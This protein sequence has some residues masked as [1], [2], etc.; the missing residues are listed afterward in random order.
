M[1]RSDATEIL[2]FFD[3]MDLA[4]KYLLGPIFKQFLGILTPKFVMPSIYPPKVC[5]FP[6]DMHYE[7][8]IIKI[9]SWVC[10]VGLFQKTLC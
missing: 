4:E 1:I 2:Q 3:F 5:S 7:I 9:G 10:S 8:L 6:G